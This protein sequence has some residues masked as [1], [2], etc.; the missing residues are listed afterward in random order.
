MKKISIIIPLLCDSE[1]FARTYESIRKQNISSDEF[2][3]IVICTVPDYCNKLENIC[4][5]LSNSTI[6]IDAPSINSKTD[7]FNHGILAANG[8]YFLFLRAGDIIHEKLFFV[9]SEIIANYSNPDLISFGITKAIDEFENF[10]DDPFASQNFREYTLCDHS[11]R[12]AFL[13]DIQIDERYYSFAYKAD[14]IKTVGQIFC[15]DLDDD[16]ITFSYPLFLFA[17]SIVATK[18]HGYCKYVT[19]FPKSAIINRI[20]DNMTAQ[21][22]LLQLLQNIPEL[23]AEYKDEIE[24]HFVQKY[25]LHSLWL[26][27]ISGEKS[28]INL[29]IFQILQFVLLQI[30]PRW[31][32][33]EFIYALGRRK[34][35][36]LSLINSSF[37]SQEELDHLICDNNTVSIIITTHNR[38]ECIGSSIKNMLFQ[39][40][41]AF[42]L[43]IIDDASTDNTENIIKTITDSRIKYIK[44]GTNMGITKVRN[45]GFNTSSTEFIAYQ[46]D[47]DL[48]RLDKLEKEMSLIWNS[49][50]EIK[51]VYP[52]AVMHPRSIGSISKSEA[53]FIPKLDKPMTQKSGFIFPSI[54]SK[55]DA[56]LT[57]MVIQKHSIEAIGGFDESIYA[58]EDWEFLLRLSQAY[59]V[60][61]I[62]EPLYDYYPRSSGIVR[63]NDSE[64]RRKLIK[65]LYDINRKYVNSRIK[66]G[67]KSTFEI[68]EQ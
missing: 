63:S 5:D 52:V 42:E 9:L 48:C 30:V 49:S 23:Y 37:H 40:Y 31:I 36:M 18:D 65:S 21:T 33:N 43:I 13:G 4:C 59:D 44:N 14:F 61:L 27:R 6:I 39:T 47:D 38:Q 7:A 32:D 34:L 41:Q 56:Q 35:D 68:T 12:S 11:A 60:I 58:Y 10:D 26:G 1:N 29:S 19:N 51:A 62:D 25:Y 20:S 46:D 2:E 64:H 28:P 8:Q 54:L 57:A 55:N 66:Y 45:I 15:D 50:E 24:A 53:D 16:E 22:N 67:I 3:I 17:N